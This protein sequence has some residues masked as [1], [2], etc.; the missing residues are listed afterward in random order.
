MTEQKRLSRRLFLATLAGTGAGVA[1]AA[2]AQPAAAPTTAP[3][4]KATDAPK[5]AATTAP[6]P[7]ATTAPAPAATQAPA[8]A[9]TPV[10]IRVGRSTGPTMAPDQLVQERFAAYSKL[11]PQ[12]KFEYE[13]VPF[14]DYFQKLGLSLSGKTA[15]DTF[16][17]NEVWAYVD[18]N[19]IVPAPKEFADDVTNNFSKAATPPTYKSQVWGYPLEGGLRL[20]LYNKDHFKEVGIP[21][22]GPQGCESW[23]QLLDW[24][25]KLTKV[26]GGEISREGWMVNQPGYWI[27]AA[28]WMWMLGG[29]FC[30]GDCATWALGKEWNEAV[31]W[32]ADAALTQKVANPKLA[33]DAFSKGLASMTVEAM[34]SVGQL[35]QFSQVNFGAFMNPPKVKGGPSL[36]DDG[37]WMF[38]VNKAAKPEVQ[39]EAWRFL[40]WLTNDENG[41]LYAKSAFSIYRQSAIA[42]AKPQVDPVIGTF[43]DAGAKYMHPR[44]PKFWRLWVTRVQGPLTKVYLGEMKAEEMSTL[45]AKQINDDIKSGAGSL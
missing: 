29:E 19:H 34:V 11:N 41:A 23:D 15:P 20:V 22:P 6:A 3:A 42:A 33:A 16:I 28:E 8:K 32:W 45:V 36:H 24:A 5:P 17:V 30:T 38:V 27:A 9:A 21:E 40:K 26:Q 31:Q 35:R 18:A 25:K 1:L 2:C 14:A 12:V 13:T 39:D 10:T 37:P 4:P 7:A 43:M 44:T